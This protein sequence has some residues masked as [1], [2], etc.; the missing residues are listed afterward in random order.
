MK[1]ERLQNKLESRYALNLA[2]RQHNILSYNIKYIVPW[3]KRFD[4]RI[5]V[6]R[7]HKRHRACYATKWIFV[8][9]SRE[10]APQAW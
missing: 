8:I 1:L 2:V 9:E 10:I 7:P 6:Y 5:V 4:G 3:K